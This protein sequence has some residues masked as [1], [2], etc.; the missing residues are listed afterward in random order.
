M[1]QKTS[2]AVK[3]PLA[4]IAIFAGISEVAMSYVLGNIS[5]KLQGIFI[6]FVVTFPFVLVG[7]FFFILYRKPAALFSP[8]DYEKDEMYLNSISNQLSNQENLKVQ[9]LEESVKILQDF[10]E[11]IIATGNHS[12]EIETNFAETRKKLDSLHAMQQNNL[13]AFMKNELELNTED[14]IKLITRTKDIRKLSLEVRELTK[15]QWKSERVE[16]IINQFPSVLS[17]FEQLTKII[18]GEQI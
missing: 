14:I 4:M 16:K 11:K 1:K 3:N 13:F 7:G 5:T 2:Q 18:I 17:D 10:M 6:W 15:D 9:Q 8:S 12:T